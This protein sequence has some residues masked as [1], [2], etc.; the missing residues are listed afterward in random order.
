[1]AKVW[2]AD[3]EQQKELEKMFASNKIL[4]NAKPSDVQDSKK[5]FEGFS[6]AVFRKKFGDLKKKYA[7]KSK[8]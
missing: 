4:Q 5:I 3:C 8:Y 2:S 7:V 6:R 1:M